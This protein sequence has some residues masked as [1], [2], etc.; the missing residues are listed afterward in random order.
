MC[1][2]F[3][4]GRVDDG[5]GFAHHHS[6]FHQEYRPLKFK[7]CLIDKLEAITPQQQTR[8]LNRSKSLP[9]AKSCGDDAW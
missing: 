8:R 6:R 2:P 4:H 5:G 7:F 9:Y 1:L 3:R